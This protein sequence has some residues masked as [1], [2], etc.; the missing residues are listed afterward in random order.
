MIILL[1][2]QNEYLI[3]QKLAGILE[4]YR[5][6]NK[7]LNLCRFDAEIDDFQNFWREFRQKSMLVESRLTV[8]E[9]I[10]QGA[11]FK[12]GF[13][14][15]LDIIASDQEIIVALETG[16]IKKADSLLIEKIKE[17]GKIQEFQQPNK[18]ETERWIVELSSSYQVKL[19]SDTVRFLVNYA[20]DDWLKGQ[21]ALVRLATSENQ[22]ETVESLNKNS[23]EIETINVFNLTGAISQGLKAQALVLA[24]R[25]FAQGGRPEGLLPLLTYQFRQI[26]VVRDLIERGY[27]YYQIKKL[28]KVPP[29]VFGKIYTQAENSSLDS[30]KKTY[31]G[32][33]DLEYKI[34]TGQLEARTG[35][36]LFVAQA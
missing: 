8:I 30:L 3:R 34:K 19:D 17:K 25:Y 20:K 29:F 13:K 16:K 12:K 10:F 9:N 22:V 1:Y 27:D 2:G 11:E 24:H 21:E 35:F 15:N 18:S 26:L 7:D 33:F 23:Q 14:K 28:S 6:K 31:A 32:L 4:R 36:D 5:H